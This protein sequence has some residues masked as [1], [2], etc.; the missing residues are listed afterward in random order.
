MSV[1]LSTKSLSKLRGVDARLVR[2]VKR[3]AELATSAEDFSVLE[4]LRTAARQRS[5]YAQGRT[6]PGR[7]VTWTLQSKHIEGK[8]VDLLPY[9]G[10]WS[11]PLS[12]FNAISRLMFRAA[13]ELGVEI[14]WGADW[15]RD[16]RP[17]ERGETDSP[18]FEL[19]E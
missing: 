6:K 7:I 17:R 3:A 13:E 10:G 4:G 8:A 9:P 16:G 12:K 14:R 1:T 19:A 15:D 5:L 2:V 18:H 11:S